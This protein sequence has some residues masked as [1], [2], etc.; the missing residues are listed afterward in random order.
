M[1]SMAKAPGCTFWGHPSPEQ[2]ICAALRFLS[3]SPRA[4]SANPKPLLPPA[5]SLLLA[6]PW[7]CCGLRL[8]K[9][10]AGQLCLLE[11]SSKNTV[12]KHQRGALGHAGLVPCSCGSAQ[13]SFY[14]PQR[15]LGIPVLA[16]LS[17]VGTAWSPLSR[18]VLKSN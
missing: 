11:N 18:L 4:T 10:P 1:N 2:N 8:N 12:S 3:W 14:L 15:P 5:C 17:P 13:G 9:A 6:Q 16:L 7:L